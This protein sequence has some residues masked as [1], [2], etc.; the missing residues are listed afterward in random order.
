MAEPCLLGIDIGTSG[1]SGVI[2]DRNLRVLAVDS[3]SHEVHSP[4]PGRAEHDA[5]DVWWTD[6]ARLSTR[7]LEQS[8]VDPEMIAGV[9]VSALHTALLPVDDDG[10]P[11]RRGILYGVDTRSTDEIEDLNDRLGED[12]IYDVCGNRLS[13]QSVG[14]KMLWYRRHEPDRFE[15]TAQFLDATG[16][17]VYRL[18]GNYTID[19]ANA[20]FFHPLYDLSA[21]EWADEMFE[22]TGLPR[23]AVPESRWATDI[24]GTVTD[25]AADATGLA[26]GTPVVVG[27]GD[28]IASLVGVAAVTDRDSIFMYGT[29]G[30][31]YTTLDEEVRS[32]KLWAFPHCL[33]DKYVLGGGMATA[34]A[35]V[36][37]F[38]DQFGA[39][40]GARSGDG[41]DSSVYQ[42]LDAEA[43]S[44]PPG[45]DGLIM[46][47]YFSGERTPMNDESARGLLAGLT[48][49][50]T[51]AHVYRAILEGIAYGFRHH[52]ETMRQAG[53]DPELVR[54]I[55]GGAGSD[56]WRQIVSDVTGVTQEYAATSIGSPLGDAYLAGLGTGVFED[57]STIEAATTVADRTQPDPT[58]SAV[59]D[60][61]YEVY[62]SL[63]PETK[64]SV[65]RLADLADGTG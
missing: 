44:V 63:Y 36:R 1:S 23:D 49:S 4:K 50:H 59:Y 46:L 58:T 65:H 51:Q 43:A 18:T 30:V 57:L 9:G 21:L 42:R 62:R 24:A 61:C 47:P 15:S 38:A 16:Y 37:W 26:A 31:I 11:L 60:E 32:R 27:T 5:E 45:A 54:A 3:V 19:K 12:R 48:L 25:A 41:D 56:L 29:T 35:V 17:V 33:E 53:V 13:Y 8:G 22:A 6:F 28:S 14:P 52:L 20:S 34:G 2:V 40:S 55:G 64:S 10:D 39:D 7:L